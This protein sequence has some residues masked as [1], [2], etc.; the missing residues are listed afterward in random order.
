[1]QAYQDFPDSR[2]RYLGVLDLASLRARLVLHRVGGMLKKDYGKGMQGFRKQ[3]AVWLGGREVH[4]AITSFQCKIQCKVDLLVSLAAAAA[5]LG[6]PLDL[7]VV[8]D[9]GD[10]LNTKVYRADALQHQRL[11]HNADVHHAAVHYMLVEVGRVPYKHLEGPQASL[12]EDSRP[13]TIQRVKLY[14]GRSHLRLLG[15]VV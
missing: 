12:L 7:E 2:Q 3:H 11:A 10:S 5:V 13:V 4:L 9:L 1:M 6:M 15:G 8:K 14:G